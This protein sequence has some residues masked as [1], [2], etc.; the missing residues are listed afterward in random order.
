M[1]TEQ[2]LKFANQLDG[3]LAASKERYGG[4]G[5]A[6]GCF[7]TV[8]VTMF[9]MLTEQQQQERL[10]FVKELQETFFSKETV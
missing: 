2:Q 10:E 7:H 6:A 5:Y 3:L 8:M 9:G 1:Y 4:Y